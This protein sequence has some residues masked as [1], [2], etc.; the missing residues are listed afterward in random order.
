MSKA[1]N[2]S[3]EAIRLIIHAD[4]WGQHPAVN[5]AIHS[6]IRQQAVTSASMLAVGPAV[7]E[8]CHFAAL[9]PSFCTGAHLSLSFGD[10]PIAPAQSVTSLTDS[11]G[12]FLRPLS[13]LEQEGDPA[14]IELE[15]S[16]QIRFLLAAGIRLTHL[17]SHQG[18]LLGIHSG[19]ERLFPVIRQLCRDYRLPFK[20]PRQTVHT[21]ALPPA[22]RTRLGGLVDWLEKQQ[23]PL[24][25]D[26]I[27]PDYHIVPGEDY[28][29]YKNGILR[30]LPTLMPGT[31]TE[32]TLHP[33]LPDEGMKEADSH[34]LKRE[35]EYRIALDEDFW[36]LLRERSIILTSWSDLIC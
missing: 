30:A 7:R 32:L 29:Q 16:A 20:L 35:W 31:I 5:Q 8:A 36:G 27:V 15:M 34:W 19:D 17:D 6:L 21:P 14:E 25:D 23:I 10:F 9:H 1:Y 18:C 22:V 4:D 26:L 28:N 33:A 24:I 13:A 3:S 11:G 12:A 2:H